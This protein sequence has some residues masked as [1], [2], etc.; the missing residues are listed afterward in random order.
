MGLGVVIAVHNCLEY[1]KQAVLSFVTDCEYEFIVIDNGSS[2]GTKD[3]FGTVDRPVTYIRKKQNTG[4]NRAWNIGIGA[5]FEKGYDAA[6]VIN[7]DIV[8]AADTVRNLLGWHGPGKGKYE[9]VT[10]SNVGSD[11][12][13]LRT[14]TR[15]HRVTKNPDFIGFLMGPKIL[16]C[17]GWFD[18]RFWPGYFGDNDYHMRLSE[19][20]F[21]AVSCLDALVAHYGS[22]TIHE[23][24]IKGREYK[25]RRKAS[26]ELFEQK[27]G[28]LP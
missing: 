19:A 23:N 17:V 25:E 22:R 21:K 6:F 11:P 8:F 7:N 5:A 1:T 26:R 10:V 4:C 12:E 2:D 13:Q 24:E 20:G 16:K 3:W 15:Q 28:F 14:H 18:E 27:W 9:F